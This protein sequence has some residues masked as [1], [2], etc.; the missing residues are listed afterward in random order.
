MALANG[1]SLTWCRV[2]IP[3]SGVPIVEADCQNEVL[4]VGGLVTFTLED[5]IV[6]STLVPKR[7]GMFAGSWQ[8]F[9]VGGRN[10]WGKYLPA[11]GYRS[12]FGLLD[13][14][15]ILDAAREA[16]ELP[17]LVAVPYVV[18]GF[19]VRRG[20]L[21]A[22]QVFSRLPAGFDWWIDPPTGVTRVSKRTPGVVTA[23]FDLLEYNTRTGRILIATDSPG[24]FA[25]GCTFIDPSAGA[26]VVNAAVI[27]SDADKLRVEVWTA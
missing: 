6:S 7:F 13:S 26:F 1:E 2:T 14:Q 8:G 17:P 15:L 3:W 19:F 27:T 20:D 9:A 16:G 18:G 5:L 10:G 21:P 11:R 24:A 23:D 25:P 4:P 12:P 22:S